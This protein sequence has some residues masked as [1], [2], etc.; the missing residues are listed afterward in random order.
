MTDT[1]ASE[2]T[3]DLLLTVAASAERVASQSLQRAI[4]LGPGQLLGGGRRKSPAIRYPVLDAPVTRPATL[5]VKRVGGYQQR[6][7]HALLD[8]AYG[9][10]PF[11]TCWCVNRLPDAVARAA[12]ALALLT[13]VLR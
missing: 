3:D 10:V 6:F 4:H 2:D 5:I 9:R 13:N 1:A 11:P 7:D 12:P 8:A